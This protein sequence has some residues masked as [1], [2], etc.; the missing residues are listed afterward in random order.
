VSRTSIT[1][2]GDGASVTAA[3]GHSTKFAGVVRSPAGIKVGD[4]VAATLTGVPGSLTVVSCQ[5]PAG[6]G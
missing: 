3:F 1:I 4:E 2:G 6:P 5:D